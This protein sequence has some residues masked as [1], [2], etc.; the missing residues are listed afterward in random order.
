M[1]LEINKESSN[2]SGLC[3]DGLPT[4]KVGMGFSLYTFGGEG[5]GEVK[6]KLL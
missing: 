4:G 3:A 5:Q 2:K 1:M 6:K